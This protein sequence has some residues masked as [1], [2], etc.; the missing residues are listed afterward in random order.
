[1]VSSKVSVPE[2]YAAEGWV[3]KRAAALVFVF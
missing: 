1:M 3:G 2:H